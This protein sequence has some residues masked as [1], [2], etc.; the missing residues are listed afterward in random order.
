MA[1]LIFP[2][3]FQHFKTTHGHFGFKTT[4]ASLSSRLL[5][6]WHSRSRVAARSFFKHLQVQEINLL[7]YSI[8]FYSILFYS[9]YSLL[10][11]Y[12]SSPLAS[13]IG[14]LLAPGEP[15]VVL[16]AEHRPGR[17]SVCRANMK[18]CRYQG[19]K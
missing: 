4:H 14:Q 5:D 15:L 6:G 3:N 17:E 10:L 8:L 7:F 11:L 16:G 13:D 18:S 9:I 1:I 12:L 19:I 2:W